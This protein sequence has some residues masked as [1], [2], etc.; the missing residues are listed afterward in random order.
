V[1]TKLLPDRQGND[2]VRD[3]DIHGPHCIDGVVDAILDRTVV[4][5]HIS[6]V[7]HIEC[8]LI[9]VRLHIALAHTEVTNDDIRLPAGRDFPAHDTDTRRRCSLTIDGDAT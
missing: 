1:S 7:S 5:Y 6:G 8:T 4:K 2:G 3:S 9:V